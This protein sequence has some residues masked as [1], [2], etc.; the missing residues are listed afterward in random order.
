MH[1]GIIC[2]L[3]CKLDFEKILQMIEEKYLVRGSFAFLSPTSVQ[4]RRQGQKSQS[5]TQGQ[6]QQ[7]QLPSGLQPSTG[8]QQ[9]N[10][11]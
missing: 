11:Q 7:L 6:Q 5:L 8:K 10:S 9:L 2:E 4:G 1:F 3:E